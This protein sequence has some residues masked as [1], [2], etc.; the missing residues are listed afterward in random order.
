MLSCS[1]V[2]C[3]E[4]EGEGEGETA[5]IDQRAVTAGKNAVL[6]RPHEGAMYVL[7]LNALILK[8]LVKE[9]QPNTNPFSLDYDYEHG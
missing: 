8:G 1:M 4:V 9:T 3:G 2:L 6:I 7:I 5:F